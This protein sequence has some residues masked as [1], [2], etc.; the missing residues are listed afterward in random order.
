MQV[1]CTATRACSRVGPPQPPA[2][3]VGNMYSQELSLIKR[4]GETLSFIFF[5]CL[6]ISSTR[7]VGGGVYVVPKVKPGSPAWTCMPFEP[8][9]GM[10][11]QV[12]TR[13]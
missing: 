8:V 12:F 6:F 2:T 3:V 1:E 13:C 10:S 9:D 11:G 5:V 7:S 4:N